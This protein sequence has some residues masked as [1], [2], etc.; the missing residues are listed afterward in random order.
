M[1]ALT[2][3]PFVDLQRHHAPLMA[4]INAAIARVTER[5][6]FI[7]G[8]DVR[9]F[10]D[11]F[12]DYCQTQHAVGVASG[13]AALEMLLRA[14]GIVSGD[15]VIV[16]A[17]TFY[18]TVYAVSAVG[19]RPVLADCDETG[20]LDPAAAE[21]AVTPRTRGILAVHLYGRLAK[22]DQLATI[23]SRADAL[24]L[25]DACQA[26]G[27]TD[28]QRRAGAFGE[29]GAFSFYPGKN[30]GAFGD[31]G[32]VVSADAGVA[33]NVRLLRDFGQPEKYR[34][35]IL[36]TNARL[37]TIQAAILRVKLP[38]LDDWNE[39]RR[40]AADRYRELLAGLPVELPAP[41]PPGEHVYHLY[42]V[43][44]SG[45]DRLRARLADLGIATGLH[46]PVPIHLLGAFSPLGYRR[47][48]FP[49]AERLA[50][51]GLS[52]PMFPEITEEQ[53]RH[54]ADGLRTALTR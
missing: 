33:E 29:G 21:A 51:E 11:E 26:H 39:H 46:Y 54:V 25:E 18:A 34:H 41:A 13:T 40:R 14:H 5:C 27:A 35:E 8:D 48:D 38:R 23:A 28:G 50:E 3:V 42:V 43:R 12:A 16:P 45:R 1:A 10:E 22:M 32:M 9:A 19:A 53:Q 24:L 30:L 17:S 52:L 20:N 6:D 15:E 49:Q 7:L 47:G 36:G 31:G 4:E 44:T 2:R 37:D